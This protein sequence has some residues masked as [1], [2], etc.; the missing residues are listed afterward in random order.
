MYCLGSIAC[1]SGG[2]KSGGDA[3]LIFMTS[4]QSWMIMKSHSH[5]RALR[6]DPGC[7]L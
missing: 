7:L 2:E 1:G 5:V 3:K 4:R 6:Y